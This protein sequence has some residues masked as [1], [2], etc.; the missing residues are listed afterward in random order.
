M[1]TII[2][3]KEV[4]QNYREALKIE[5]KT[6]IE[7]TGVIPHLTVIIVGENPASQTY[8][9]NKKKGCEETGFK[10]TIIELPET[11]SESELLSKIEALN[12][13]D[14]VHGIL[15][16]LP[17]PKHI[18]EDHVIHAISE[19]KDVDGFHPNQVGRLA[20]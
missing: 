7:Q 9:R 14:S 3:G 1:T 5:T 17:L 13:D 4:A 19:H 15:V 16:Q 10:S 18:N 2:N 6:F 12:V 8:V 20:S 11:I